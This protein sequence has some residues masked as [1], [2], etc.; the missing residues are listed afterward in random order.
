MPRD[1]PQ[2]RQRIAEAVADIDRQMLQRV[3]QELDY[4]ID[5]CRRIETWNFSSSVDMLPFGVTIPA[6]VPQR[7]EIPV[8]V[9][10]LEILNSKR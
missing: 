10:A 7:S 3:W 6:T 1:L 8:C 5:I 2:T 9:H 4:R